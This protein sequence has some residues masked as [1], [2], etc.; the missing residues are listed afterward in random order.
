MPEY[1]DWGVID[2]FKL[3]GFIVTFKINE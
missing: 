3:I 1:D 2:M